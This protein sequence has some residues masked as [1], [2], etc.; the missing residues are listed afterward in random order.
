M[1]DMNQCKI[2]DFLIS[3]LGGKFKYISKDCNSPYPHMVKHMDGEFK[4]SF[5]TRLDDGRVAKNSLQTDHNIVGFYKSKSKKI[6][7]E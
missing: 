4:G 2:G 7:K 1:F 5:G 6:N 3:N